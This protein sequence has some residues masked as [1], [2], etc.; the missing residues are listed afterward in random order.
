M[1]KIG[2]GELLRR[3]DAVFEIAHLLNKAGYDSQL[4]QKTL[5]DPLINAVN[6]RI[7]Y[8]AMSE[9]GE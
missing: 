3:V 5:I 6:V 7:E 2:I 9:E 1:P 8:G 4:I